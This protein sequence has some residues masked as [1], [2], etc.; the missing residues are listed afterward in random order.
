MD[1]L[2]KAEL[3]TSFRHIVKFL[4]LE[5]PVHNFEVP[6]MAGRIQAIAK[7]FT[8][9]AKALIRLLQIFT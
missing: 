5:I 1:I 6:N 7:R 9:D 8:F 4:K 2:E 3:T